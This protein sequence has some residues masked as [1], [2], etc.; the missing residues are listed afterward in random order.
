MMNGQKNIKL[1]LR[2]R[3]NGAILPLHLYAFMTCVRT[4]LLAGQPHEVDCSVCVASSQP[5]NCGR[6]K[7]HTVADRT[8]WAKNEHCF[9]S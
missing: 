1:M 4:V 9:V 8:N 6:R 7:R 3:M 5:Y 2:L